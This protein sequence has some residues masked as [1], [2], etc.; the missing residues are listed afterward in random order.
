MS[1]G[2]AVASKELIARSNVAYVVNWLPT[3]QK[4]LWIHMDPHRPLRSR[5]MRRF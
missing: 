4:I 2:S 1:S 5:D 3:Y